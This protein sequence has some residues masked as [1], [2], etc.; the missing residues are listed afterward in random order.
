MRLYI[1]FGN[2]N[3]YIGGMRKKD[4]MQ[5]GATTLSTLIV[6]ILA[7]VLLYLIYSIIAPALK[8][9]LTGP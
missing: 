8:T 1:L 6:V 7:I 2:Q 4:C 9:V 5:K 3:L